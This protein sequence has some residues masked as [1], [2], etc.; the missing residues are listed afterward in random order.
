MEKLLVM[1]FYEMLE[2]KR[3]YYE[4]EVIKNNDGWCM[5][6]VIMQPFLILNIGS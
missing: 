2:N 6:I 3:N 5:K 1:S 4:Y